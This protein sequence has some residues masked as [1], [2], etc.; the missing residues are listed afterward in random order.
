MARASR[1]TPE[2]LTPA[3]PSASRARRLRPALRP[4]AASPDSSARARLLPPRR[5]PR[6]LPAA[7]PQAMIVRSP[8]ALYIGLNPIGGGQYP[9]SLMGVFASVRQMLLDARRY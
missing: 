8:V 5:T 7:S 2:S 9:G 1:S 4:A 3:P 6:R